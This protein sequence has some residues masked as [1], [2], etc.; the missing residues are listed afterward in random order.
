[1]ADVVLGLAQEHLRL[2]LRLD[3]EV[4]EQGHR[5]GDGVSDGLPVTAVDVGGQCQAVGALVVRRRAGDP[6]GPRRRLVEVA[7]DEEQFAE[8]QRR[9]R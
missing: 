8:P 2:R 4:V 9:G 3:A 7:G 5:R 6:V 1:M